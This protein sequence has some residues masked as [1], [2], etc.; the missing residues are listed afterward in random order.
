MLLAALI[1]FSK[2]PAGHAL[3][4]REKL[5]ALVFAVYFLI[6]AARGLTAEHPLKILPQILPNVVFI[7][8]G[9]LLAVL[10][11]QF[12]PKYW[13]VILIL[14]AMGG[15]AAGIYAEYYVIA[16]MRYFDPRTGNPLVLALFC[17]LIGLISLERAVGRP[18]ALPWLHVAGFVGAT[19]AVWL[20]ARRSAILAYFI[21]V[22]VVILWNARQA[23]WLRL[24]AAIMIV[25]AALTVTPSS[26]YA[27]ERFGGV[28]Q[29]DLAVASQEAA[30]S[31]VPGDELAG[32]A[33]ATEKPAV[34]ATR[35]MTTSGADKIRF[36]MYKGGARAFLKRPFVGYG[37]QN[38]VSAANGLRDAGVPS[39]GQYNHLHSAP[40][41]EAV[42]AGVIGVAAFFAVLASPLVILLGAGGSLFKSSTV[43]LLFFFLCSALN[44]GFYMDATS[45]I[46][47]FAVCMLNALSSRRPNPPSAPAAS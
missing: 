44:V 39:F 29:T 10:R 4:P 42:A 31:G 25:G 26:F 32:P 34:A 47:V 6:G 45:S 37:R 46:F 9:P 28:T 40:L 1:E 3:L 21:C 17:G 11:T 12:A 19:L 18:S 30:P 7:L 16:N 38:A 13:S 2:D 43:C 27:L 20:T 41:T 8:A 15:V 24:S 14:I 36:S 23:P 22:V 5:I 33:Q 35:Q